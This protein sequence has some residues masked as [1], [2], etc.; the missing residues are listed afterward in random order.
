MLVEWD[1]A[2]Y[3][4]H[5][6]QCVTQSQ[7]FEGTTQDASVTQRKALILAVP[8]ISKRVHVCVWLGPPWPRTRCPHGRHNEVI[9]GEYKLTTSQWG[10]WIEPI[11]AAAGVFLFR[12]LQEWFTG[13]AL[14]SPQPS[15]VTVFCLFPPLFS[16]FERTKI[17]IKNQSAQA[18]KWDNNISHLILSTSNI[19]QPKMKRWRGQQK[20]MN[21]KM[22]HASIQYKS[23]RLK[24]THCA[25]F[26]VCNLTLGYH[27][28]R[29]TCFSAQRTHP[30]SHTV[31][32]WCSVFPLFPFRLC[33]KNHWLDWKTFFLMCCA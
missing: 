2:S 33:R 1:L 9:S 15:S 13:G 4:L 26:Q 12:V 10:C 22:R 8:S 21:E 28:T 19:I 29:C 32:C 30:F 23:L 3:T 31:Q 16:L 20:K 17:V 5:T 25:H 18:N 6:L 14:S 11:V 7:M 27:Q 24:E